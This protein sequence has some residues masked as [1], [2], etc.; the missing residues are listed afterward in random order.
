MTYMNTLSQLLATGMSLTDAMER[1][2]QM[3]MGPPMKS[4][5]SNGLN[6]ILAAHAKEFSKG[7]VD[8]ILSILFILEVFHEA[9]SHM[10]THERVILFRNIAKQKG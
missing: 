9:A 10:K 5:I 3:R 1:I 2:K 6:N 4:K 8:T 7:E